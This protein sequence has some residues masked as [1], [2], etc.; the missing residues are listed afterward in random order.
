V[1][2]VG[3]SINNIIF[4]SC[5]VRHNFRSSWLHDDLR[6]KWFPFVAMRLMCV[7]LLVGAI[8]S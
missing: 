6:Q 5:N 7:M 4:S 8:A 1:H 3:S 2:V